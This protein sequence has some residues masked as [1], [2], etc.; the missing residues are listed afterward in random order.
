MKKTYIDNT[1]I[2]AFKFFSAACLIAILA[3]FIV[4][5]AIDNAITW[6]LYPLLSVPFGWLVLSP[7][8]IKRFGVL[9]SLC[10][11]MIFVMPF[12]FLLDKI[13]PVDSWFIGIGIPSAI[14]GVPFLWLMYLLFRFVKINLWFKS[15]IT[16]FLAGVVL[17]PVI[18]HYISVFLN[19]TPTF[20]NRFINVF[21]CFVV[22]LLLVVLGIRRKNPAPD[23]SRNQAASW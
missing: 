13:T 3:C 17:N 22:A 18:N 10:S 11:L 2:L 20:F 23:E 21:P 6:A 15:A 16:V 19:E 5:I 9:F 1:G 8:V 12:L 4:N 14:A 7:L